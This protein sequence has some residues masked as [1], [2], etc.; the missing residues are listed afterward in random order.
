MLP[1][2]AGVVVAC[3]LRGLAQPGARALG[4]GARGTARM[5][6]SGSTIEVE[7]KFESRGTADELRVAVEACGGRTV[8]EVRFSDAYW[9]TA[10]CTL[11]R[12]DTWLRR[13]TTGA[14]SAWELKIPL[15]PDAVRSG[16]ERTVFREVVGAD[17][18]RAALTTELGLDAGPMSGAD[19]A[20]WLARDA[21]MAPFAEF[22]TV[23]PSTHIRHGHAGR[24]RGT[25]PR[26]CTHHAR[27]QVRSKYALGQCA[28]DADVASFGHSVLEIEVRGI[29]SSL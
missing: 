27:A 4:V 13:R 23:R 6:T 9:D 28:L 29:D 8:G 17:A 1:A 25:S 26:T 22:E 24:V 10:E 21:R 14:D 11:T 3:A 2:V 18:V 12:Q 5:A 7:R 16:G 15:G 19:L 20:E